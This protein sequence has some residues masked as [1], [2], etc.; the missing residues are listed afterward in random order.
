M[1]DFKHPFWSFCS[2]YSRR[3]NVITFLSRYNTWPLMNGQVIPDGLIKKDEPFWKNFFENVPM[4]QFNHRNMAYITM[5]LS[6]YLLYK[7]MKAKIGGAFTVAGLLAVMMINYQA[8][9]G[10]VTLLNLVPK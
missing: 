9:S 10:I 4:V 5:S 1:L 8:A 3:K 2:R 6:Y 7:I